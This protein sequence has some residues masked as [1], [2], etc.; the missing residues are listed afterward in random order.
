L[1]ATA[2]EK[3]VEAISRP[4]S[5]AYG[6][7]RTVNELAQQ[8]DV[9]HSAPPMENA[10]SLLLHFFRRERVLYPC[11]LLLETEAVRNAGGYD[12]TASVSADT[13]LWM[14]IMTPDGTA[15]FVPEML[16]SYTVHSANLTKAA[17]ISEWVS[18]VERQIEA[19]LPSVTQRFGEPA[20]QAISSASQSYLAHLIAGLLVQKRRSGVSL[21]VLINEV[22]AYN[23]YLLT[24]R[25]VAELL[26]AMFRMAVPGE[27]ETR[28]RRLRASVS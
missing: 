23:H 13:A 21:K 19:V 28:V 27:L 5:L 9:S 20:A 10:E 25:G 7:V 4:A 16:S 2:I 14:R 24:H 18:G 1:E 3:L 6:M 22:L 15:A 8:I 11:C 12:N 26:R 17:N